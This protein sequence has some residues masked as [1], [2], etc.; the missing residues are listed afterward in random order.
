MFVPT[1][2]QTRLPIHLNINIEP[3]LTHLSIEVRARIVLPEMDPTR[4]SLEDLLDDL[5]D[6]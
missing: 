5:C 1:M 4:M 2:Y 6:G 3:F